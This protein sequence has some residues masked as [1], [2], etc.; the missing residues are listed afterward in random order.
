MKIEVDQ[1]VLNKEYDQIGVITLI[2]QDT[3]VISYDCG[4]S[5]EVLI[6]DVFGEE[7]GLVERS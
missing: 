6:S 4:W 5:D 7:Y 1:E 2:T 3:V